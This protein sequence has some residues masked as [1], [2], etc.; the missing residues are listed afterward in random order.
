MVLSS[1]EGLR[2]TRQRSLAPPMTFE[3]RPARASEQL[4]PLTSYFKTTST[5]SQG[6]PCVAANTL[7]TASATVQLATSL[8]TNMRVSPFFTS[9]TWSK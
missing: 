9:S 3:A 8:P 7:A 2:A 4:L 6:T 5:F 1:N